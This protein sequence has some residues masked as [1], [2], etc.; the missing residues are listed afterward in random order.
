MDLSGEALRL[1]LAGACLVSS[2]RAP[3]KQMTSCVR[4]S[5]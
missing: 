1:G 2:R 5:D 4:P 3:A